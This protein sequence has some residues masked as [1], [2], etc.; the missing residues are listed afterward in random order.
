MQVDLEAP[1]E[2]VALLAARG[3]TRP[4][5]TPGEHHRPALSVTAADQP[6]ITVVVHLDPTRLVAAGTA[7]HDWYRSHRHPTA[8]PW[9]FAVYLRSGVWGSTDLR[10][11]TSPGDIT[12][13][14]STLDLGAAPPTAPDAR[15]E[16]LNPA[17]RTT[18]Q[19]TP[20]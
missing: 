16:P 9:R 5:P 10:P 19:E 4:A 1:A 12:R 6:A 15:S 20:A 13:L 11:S 17:S 3:A 18:Q 14:L 2:L 7:I 8:R